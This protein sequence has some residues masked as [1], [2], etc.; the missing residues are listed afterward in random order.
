MFVTI[1]GNGTAMTSPLTLYA[2]AT[3]SPKMC[4]QLFFD[5][6]VSITDVTRCVAL[7]SLVPRSP[8]MLMYV[9][10]RACSDI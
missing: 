2:A 9:D 8:H 4:Q 6:S 3:F 10:C 7:Y 1:S 5:E